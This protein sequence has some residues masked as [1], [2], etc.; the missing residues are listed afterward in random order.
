MSKVLF[1][2]SAA[3]VWTLKDG[4][5]YP[6]GYWG[7]ELAVPHRLFR[8]AGWDI[9][10]ATPGAVAPTLDETS[11]GIAGGLPKKRKEIREYLDSIQ[12]E[13]DSPVDLADVNADDFDVVF[14]PGGH[15]P[16]EDLSQD[17][18]SG[19]LLARR[20]ETNKPVGLLCHA[21]AAILAAKK[22]DGTNVF[23]GRRMTGFS[24]LEEKANKASA[25]AKWLLED[26]MKAAGVD[27]SS[28][29]PMMSHV[30]EDGSVFTGQNPA[31]SEKLAKRLIEVAGN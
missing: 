20:V 28:G 5:E 13:L 30:V 8:E 31:S 19:A 24:N 22:E 27:Y 3:N 23:A 2:V 4:S 17:A 6:T 10:I 7:E 18:T 16:M 26:E 12:V 21:P 11:M 25:K 29:V 1:V 14:Y 15:G 9:T